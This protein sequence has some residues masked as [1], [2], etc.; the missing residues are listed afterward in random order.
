MKALFTVFTVLSFC[1]VTRAQMN[2]QSLTGPVTQSEINSFKSYMLTQVAPPTPWGALIDTN[3]DHNEWADF[4][5]GN[6]LEAF[7]MIYEVSD[8]ITVLTNM[9]HWTDIC[10]SE[11]NDLMSAANGG[12]RVMWTNGI[13]KVWC[14]EPPTNT[15]AGG[16]NGDTKAHVLYTALLILQNPSLW[17]QTVPDGNLYGYGVTYFQRATNYLRKCD[18]ANDNYDYLFIS[19]S[20]TIA[21]PPDWPAGFHTMFANNI[22]MM[23]LGDFERSAQCH[24]ILGDDPARLSYYDMIVSNSYLQCINGM[25]GYHPSTTNGYLV[26]DWAYYPYSK[27]PSDEENVGHGAYDMIGVWRAYGR[28]KYHF[29]L[30]AVLPFASAVVDVMNLAT[31][32]FSG[33]VDGSGTA[34]NYMQQQWLLLADWRTP[35]YDTIAQADY[36]SGRYKT[37]PYMDAAI[38]WMKNRRYL[39]FSVTPAVTAPTLSVGSSTNFTVSVAPLGGFSNAVSLAVNGLPPGANGTFISPVVNLAA[40]NYVSTNVTLSIT[41]SGSTPAGIYPLSIVSTS[42]SVSHTNVITL[43]VGNFSLSA[44]PPSQTISSGT[45]TS[46]L[47][48]VATNSGFSG[49]V[50]FG[51]TGLPANTTAGFSP[52][53]LSGAGSSTL[54]VNAAANI[55]S[56]LYTLTVNATNGPIVGA[57]TVN[58]AVVGTT[59]VWSGGSSSDSYWSDATNWEGNGITPDV[60]LIFSGNS[61]L[62]NTNDTAAGTIY[63][64]I[65]FNSGAGAFVLNGN[66]I[67]MGG[68]ITN[69]SVNPQTFNLDLSFNNNFVLDGVAGPL[70]ILGGLT[71]TL[72]AAG[73]TSVTL[74]GTG[75]LADSWSSANNPGG[76]NFLS[77]TDNAANWTI[78]D[79]ASSTAIKTGPWVWQI[80]SGTVNFGNGS[81][82]PNLNLNTAVSG[83]DNFVGSLNGG[84]GTLNINSGTLTTVTRWDTGAFNSGATGII[85]QNG[86]AFGIGSQFQGANI[87]GGASLVTINGGAMTIS[88]GGGPFYV[89]SRGAGTLTMGGSGTL[90][91]GILDISRNASGNSVGSVGTVNLNGGTLMCNRVGT[92]TA[93]SQTNWLLGS[94]ATFNFNGGTLMA[95]VSAT[96]FFLG[97]AALPVIPVTAIVQTGGAVIDDGGNAITVGEPL[98][99]DNTLAGD[100]DGGLTKL[101]NGTLTLTAISTYN[102]NTLVNAGTLVLSDAGSILDSDSITVTGGATLDASLRADGTLTLTAGQILTGNG[103]VKG[104]VVVG[105]G[106]ILAPGGSLS[107]LT[108]DNN[109]TLNSGSAIVF[110]VSKSPAVNDFAQVAGSLV[111][112][113]TIFVTN[114]SASPYAAGDSFT[115]FNA[116]SRSGIFTSIQPVIPAVNLAWNTNNLS[117]GVLSIVSSPTQRP[118]IRAAT[119]N[120]GNFTFDATNGVP[121]WPSLILASTNL[122]LPLNQWTALATNNFDANGNFT[123]TNQPDPAAPQTFYLLQLQ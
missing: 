85:N 71:D 90:N 51:V 8:D 13:A 117:N 54:T 82:A 57:V 6:A 91:C 87:G 86:G 76:T 21:N 120:N 19:P 116:A 23:M 95:K 67:T 34:Q 79:N 84:I 81:D 5:G 75:I 38:L 7:G 68:N 26:Y 100:L 11:R 35:V 114:V 10:V 44:V 64:N 18:E 3:S 108:F 72:G 98:R 123:F 39:E 92:A 122:A 48:T 27:Y 99:H 24:E 43:A 80:S 52:S 16:E 22:Q 77:L 55:S 66:S 73:A 83:Q 37:S 110:E 115:L 28:L 70:D 29:S 113:G 63:S 121:Y 69:N 20:N 107:T 12:Q 96:N 40:L 9:I 111:L 93:N 4:G 36:A 101:D 50:F 88:G 31:N 49:T 60:P 78:A 105:N 104:N 112:N 14:P 74:A 89:A 47:I 30:P 102:G 119:M 103:V 118:Y 94:A 56:G 62:N 32:S 97:S 33:N 15:Y 2:I 109:V 1:C 61:R 106:A 41:T 45:G 42:G 59:P 46:Y 25:A 65:V 53:S 58:L 17:N